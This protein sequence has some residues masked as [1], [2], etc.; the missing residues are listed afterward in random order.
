[1]IDALIAWLGWVC[2]GT[3][4]VI[5]VVGAIGMIR[6]PDIYTRMHAASVSETAGAI[7]L[8]VGMM[9]EAGLTLVTGKLVII[10]AVILFSVPVAAHALAQAALHEGV[11]PV[12]A[13]RKILRARDIS[14]KS[15][16]KGASAPKATKGARPSK[17][18]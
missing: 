12:L 10:L 7:L 9:L 11:E 3:G 8:L 17:R 18:Q 6:F 16:E 4:G 2:L 15:S 1:M 14:R 13:D 5:Y